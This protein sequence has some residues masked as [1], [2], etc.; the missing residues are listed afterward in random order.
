M[1][2]SLILKQWRNSDQSV[3]IHVPFGHAVLSKKHFGTNSVIS[4][5]ASMNMCSLVG[6]FCSRHFTVKLLTFENI[7][8]SQYSY[9]S[10]INGSKN[11]NKFGEINI[12]ECTF[13]SSRYGNESHKSLG[14][15]TISPKI[16]FFFFQIFFFQI[17]RIWTRLSPIN[18]SFDLPDGRPESPPIAPLFFIRLSPDYFNESSRLFCQLGRAM[19][20]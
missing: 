12:L 2:S 9:H 11:K 10:F 8:S 13:L 1:H 3:Y 7:I 4:D 17:G 5:Q 16:V 20:Q 19:Y 18:Q 14:Y 15:A 6:V